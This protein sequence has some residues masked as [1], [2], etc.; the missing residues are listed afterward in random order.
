[1]HSNQKA[2]NSIYF[3]V[4][5]L[6]ISNLAFAQD[7]WVETTQEDFRD[8]AYERNLYASHLGGGA[9]EYAPRFDLNNDGYL[10]LF[11]ADRSGPYAKIYWGDAAGY[12]STNVTLFPT[13]A[14]GN[15]DAADLNGDGYTDFVVMH[16]RN[17][18]HLSIYWGSPTGPSSTNATEIPVYQEG[19]NCYIADFNK[20]GYL[21]IV[22]GASLAG[23]GAVFWG[24]ATGF[25]FNNRTDL[26]QGIGQ[27]NIE[28]AD[29]NKDNWLDI[30]YPEYVSSSVN[31]A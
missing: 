25:S 11:T 8:G 28:V 26:P 16:F 17:S 31:R 13:N 4:C 7:M 6:L 27:H 23:Y 12:S 19:E 22:T 9:V 1:M 20:D 29:F 10:D 21:D 15:C 3:I 30:M 14:A 24:S 5:T 2:K 18:E